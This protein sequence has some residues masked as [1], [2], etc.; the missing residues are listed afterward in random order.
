MLLFD[1]V[2]DFDFVDRR[3]HSC[4]VTREIVK[5]GVAHGGTN[6]FIV[7]GLKHFDDVLIVWL[8]GFKVDAREFSRELGVALRILDEALFILQVVIIPVV[9]LFLAI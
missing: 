2:V 1:S 3:E 4:N 9:E 5:G 6:T 7:A 8:L